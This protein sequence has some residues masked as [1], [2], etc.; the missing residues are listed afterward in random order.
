L[1][2]AKILEYNQDRRRNAEK[3]RYVSYGNS[4][5]GLWKAHDDIREGGAARVLCS[6]CGLSIQLLDVAIDVVGFKV[7][8]VAVTVYT[9]AIE[10]E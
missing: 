2:G 6:L 9:I 5:W 7:Q 4:M 3:L 10:T 8:A 1:F